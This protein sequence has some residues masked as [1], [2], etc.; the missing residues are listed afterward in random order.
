MALEAHQWRTAAVGPAT[1]SG[2]NDV[3]NAS[4]CISQWQRKKSDISVE[5][6]SGG[7]LDAA[8]PQ[9]DVTNLV[10]KVA[11]VASEV[12][13]AR[14]RLSFN[15]LDES[16]EYEGCGKNTAEEVC[17]AGQLKMMGGKQQI[18]VQQRLA[19]LQSTQLSS[20]EK[21][22]IQKRRE[23]AAQKR[24]ESEKHDERG[25]ELSELERRLALRRQAATLGS[26]AM[27]AALFASTPTAQQGELSPREVRTAAD[28]EQ[29]QANA[30]FEDGSAPSARA[31]AAGDKQEPCLLAD[32]LELELF[33]HPGID[34]GLDEVLTTQA[35][36][37]FSKPLP[38]AKEDLAVARGKIL[39]STWSIPRK[40]QQ[41]VLP[42]PILAT[43][44][45]RA[46][47]SE[48]IQN[49][50]DASYTFRNGFKQRL[51]SAD[52]HTVGE[53]GEAVLR[54]DIGS[55]DTEAPDSEMW[56]TPPHLQ[57]LDSCVAPVLLRTL[58]HSS[59]QV[60]IVPSASG[61]SAGLQPFH[62][63]AVPAVWN[64]LL[65]VT[66]LGIDPEAHIPL[67]YDP[68]EE[69][70]IGS[71]EWCS[72]VR[73]RGCAVV[74][75]MHEVVMSSSLSGW[76]QVVA[77]TASTGAAAAILT[78]DCLENDEPPFPM[79]LF[80]DNPPKIPGFM[81]GGAAGAFMATA[82]TSGCSVCLPTSVEGLERLS[83]LQVRKHLSY[84][85][86]RL[87]ERELRKSVA[88]DAAA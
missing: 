80:G 26:E 32:D 39:F 31:R 20:D 4:N 21:A 49:S 67:F 85:E 60:R 6:G 54:F 76:C 74:L 46:G 36:E 69:A 13:D 3:K 43:T 25:K 71:A 75:S 66:G 11:D 28:V 59:V 50:C 10:A 24:R 88:S 81:L 16:I 34:D 9:A 18:A 7:K 14:R 40:A 15:V 61:S 52:A 47:V 87:E 30:V 63:P 58:R 19:A 48:A 8:G 22:E 56:I 78:F 29:L 5:G 86:E 35:A 65:H 53:A 62:L 41:P 57:S 38:A 55:S 1:W 79:A 27:D 64:Q 42:A 37:V 82:A 33:D 51:S 44:P 45:L 83:E 70:E 68:A 17:S 77:A 72:D 23:S 73:K 2:L 84:L 12:S